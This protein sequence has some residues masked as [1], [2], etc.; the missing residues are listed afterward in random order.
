ARGAFGG[1]VFFSESA[2]ADNATF[3]IK[4]GTNGGQGGNLYLTDSSLGGTAQV[5]LSGNATVD[6]T[7][8][9]LGSVSIG[10]LAGTGLVLLGTTNLT[11]GSNNFTTEFSGN[12]RDNVQPPFA[13]FTKTGSGNL[14]LSG[15]NAYDWVT[16]V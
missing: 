12:I 3:T 5:K 11:V 2:T 4:G 15:A 7:Y 6:M 13:S 16:F 8:H 1:F 9:D 14:A 10:S